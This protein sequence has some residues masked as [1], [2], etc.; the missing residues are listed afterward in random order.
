[1]KLGIYYD[2]YKGL[3]DRTRVALMKKNNFECTFLHSSSE[4]L[5]EEVRVI[6][7]ADITVESLHAPYPTAE[8]GIDDLWIDDERGDISAGWC[9]QSWGIIWSSFRRIAIWT[10]Y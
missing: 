2:C 3:D 9:V 6:R 5:Y 4:R 8:G 10:K 7:E 1:M